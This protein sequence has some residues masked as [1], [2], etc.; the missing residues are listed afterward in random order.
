MVA[1][2]SRERVAA[3]AEIERPTTSRHPSGLPL[4]LGR[5]RD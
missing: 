2:L 5:E 1:A 4:D 3:K